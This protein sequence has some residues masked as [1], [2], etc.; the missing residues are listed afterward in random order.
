MN[1]VREACN[2]MDLIFA[3]LNQ[4]NNESSNVVSNEVVNQSDAVQSINGRFDGLTAESF[5]TDPNE[6]SRIEGLG[7][8]QKASITGWDT[9][10]VSIY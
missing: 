8:L 9:T 6:N 1:D 5:S 10:K 3:A 7:V 2:K 4:V